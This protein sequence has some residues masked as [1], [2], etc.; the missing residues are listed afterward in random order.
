VIATTTKICT[1]ESSTLFHKS[2]SQLSQHSLTFSLRKAEEVKSNWIL[3][4]TLI[5]RAN[6][7]DW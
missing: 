1:Y 4:L 2:A 7:F 6:T 5:F 3:Y